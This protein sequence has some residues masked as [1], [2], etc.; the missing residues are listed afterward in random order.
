MLI[1]T[2][3]LFISCLRGTRPECRAGCPDDN[4][5]TTVRREPALNP[6]PRWTRICRLRES[7]SA[8]FGP[9]RLLAGIGSESAINSAQAGEPWMQADRVARHYRPRCRGL[10]TSASTVS[11]RCSP[12]RTFVGLLDA[13]EPV[14]RGRAGGI[15]GAGSR[16]PRLI[17]NWLE[18][19]R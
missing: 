4:R 14:R 19:F 16:L 18:V 9:G 2:R 11:Q 3:G 12:T 7:H 5:R 17:T 8:R 6:R 15:G 10:C 1:G 13:E